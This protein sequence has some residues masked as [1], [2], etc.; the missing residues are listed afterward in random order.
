MNK[1]IARTSLLENNCIIW[2]RS[3]ELVQYPEAIK[4]MEECVDNIIHNKENGNIWFLEHPAIYTVGASSKDEDLLDKNVLP[5]Y[6]TSRGGQ[7]TYHGPGQRVV[8]LMLNLK[9][10]FSPKEPDLSSF[11]RILEEVII[12]CLGSLGIVSQTVKGGPGVWV[13]TKKNTFDK[14][15]AI[16]IRVRKWVCYHGI[17]VNINPNL[18]HFKGIIPCGIKEHG[19]T[20]LEELGCKILMNDFDRIFK[21]TLEKE[22]KNARNR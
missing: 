6:K 21:K 7:I 2:T 3:D 14:I 16:G 22:L 12:E 13:K 9:K 10:I 4:Y 11:V 15:A 8:Y 17:A 1:I 19:V 5:I 18:D 20:S